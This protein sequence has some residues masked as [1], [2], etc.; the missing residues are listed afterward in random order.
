MEIGR[1][2]T[3][4]ERVTFNLS[5]N[6]QISR[7]KERER[8]TISANL[9]DRFEEICQDT[10]F[11]NISR[12]DE[13]EKK[14]KGKKEKRNVLHE[15]TTLDARIERTF[16]IVTTTRITWK[17]SSNEFSFVRNDRFQFD[18][19]LG[20]WL[21]DT[22]LIYSECCPFFFSF[23]LKL[24]VN[25]TRFVPRIWI[26]SSEY[27]MFRRNEYFAIPSFRRSIWHTIASRIW[28][29]GWVKYS[30][31]KSVDYTLDLAEREW[32]LISVATMRRTCIFGST[33]C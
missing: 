20:D 16:V 23:F 13:N 33:R 3:E 30:S 2:F 1:G 27:Y 32:R 9:F 28:P 21:R 6:E 25:S 17:R 8:E 22:F 7:Q 31:R 26:N 24:H 10:R 14:G 15:R 12:M 5:S 11:D 4:F 18:S 19:L 29:R